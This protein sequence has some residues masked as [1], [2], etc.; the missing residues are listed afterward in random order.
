MQILFV[1]LEPKVER[2]RG[3]GLACRLALASCIELAPAFTV[4]VVN[5]KMPMLLCEKHLQGVGG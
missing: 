1:Y 3:E 5:R 4:E 2:Y